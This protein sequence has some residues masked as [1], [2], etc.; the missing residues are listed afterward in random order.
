M[1]DRTL[2]KLLRPRVVFP[3]LILLLVLAVVLSP[4][5][6][7][8]EH[9]LR[10][11]THGTGEWNAKGLYDVLKLL[12]R[13]VSQREIPMRAPLDSAAVYFVLQ[14]PE[15]PSAREA[16]ALLDAVRRGA[17][18]VTVAEPGGPLTDSIRI[19][20]TFAR[21]FGA[22]RASPDTLYGVEHTDHGGYGAGGGSEPE[23]SA[24]RESLSA[25]ERARAFLA[26]SRG[27]NARSF[28]EYLRP[29]TASDT[30]STRVFPSDT[31][32]LLSAKLLRS[33][34]VVMGR[35]IGRGRVVVIA[36]GS[37]LRN[38][39]MSRGDAAVLLVRLLAWADTTGTLP[40]VFDEYHHGYGVHPGLV[41]T[42]RRAL[43]GTPAGRAT[44]WLAFAA[45]VLLL[46]AS[47]RPI[48]P[49]PPVVIER[50]SPLEHVSALSRAYAAIGAT[51]LAVRRLVRGLRR[52]H[53]LGAVGA[54]DDD[55]YLALVRA[56]APGTTE[57]VTLLARAIRT[58]LPASEF[59]HAGAAIDH[60]ERTLTS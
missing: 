27:E 49:V 31:V 30:D 16:S 23:D 57:D 8:A 19:E 22:M 9:S 20:S 46:A 35:A 28:H 40:L 5:E 32:T 12:G 59:V 60:I 18:L 14:P 25:R 47:V 24:R 37:F 6:G 51:R 3:A 42:V 11:S 15:D 36:D 39:I 1:A 7:E 21:G 52:R 53:P 45:L 29:T 54:L 13:N 41:P 33:H 50:R 43:L 44:L 48:A 4:G 58:P 55:G 38:G 17:S 10:L 56:R 2:D 34:P 26:Q